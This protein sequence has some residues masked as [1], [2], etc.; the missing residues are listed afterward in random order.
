MIQVEIGDILG[1]K[2]QTLT[3]TVNCVGV[4]GKGIALAF[5][6]RFP[7]MYDDYVKRCSAG[8]VRLGEPYLYR[9]QG[10]P[11]VLNFPTKDHWRS[12]TRL[13]DVV[14]GLEYLLLRYKA[15]GITSLAVPPLG[16]GNGQ[17]D[18]KVVGPTLHRYLSKLE[19]PV[20][21]Y[22]PLGTPAEQLK[23]SFLSKAGAERDP[24]LPQ[25]IPVFIEPSWI[26]I[27]GTLERIAREPYRWPIRRVS[28]QKLVYF[29][30]DAGL[31]TG[32]TF[33]KSEFGPFSPDL[34]RMLTKLVNNGLILETRDGEAFEVNVGPTFADAKKSYRSVLEK[35]RPLIEK[36]ADLFLRLNPR[37]A[38][39]A[40]TTVFAS[41]ALKE[42]RQRPPEELE[43]LDYVME[44]KKGR[45]PSWDRGEVAEMIR[46]MNSLGFV[47][48]SASESLPVGRR[49]LLAA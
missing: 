38:E 30:T 24:S 40:A 10:V 26:V 44:W 46:D 21:L 32:L 19:I 31:P 49:F 34:K 16:C 12:V 25:K 48:L 29:L 23:L 11:W 33:S 2:R 43:V 47:T 14:R 13:E 36:Y 1:S 3:N 17:L 7:E 39:I 42:G 20:D 27:A 9:E 5:K 15:W 6:E 22:A 18:W 37:Q 28:F 45:K 8:S 4:M 35:W 41:G